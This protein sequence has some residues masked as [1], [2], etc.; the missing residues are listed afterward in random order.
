MDANKPHA[1]EVTAEPDRVSARTVVAFALALT[2]ITAASM[3]LMAL[4]FWIYQRGADRTDA[5]AISAA[6]LENR[7]AVVPPAPR[8]LVDPV[9][10]WRELRAAET[11]RLDSYGWLDRKAG[12]VHIPIERAIEIVAQRG[13][14][15]LP[16]PPVA[17]PP[18]QT[19]PPPPETKK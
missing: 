16:P 5:A 11:R 1:H 6:G 3:A 13:V 19:A 8:L 14:A 7:E 2:L 18:V 4:L 17:V 12:A 9:G 10:H 15:P